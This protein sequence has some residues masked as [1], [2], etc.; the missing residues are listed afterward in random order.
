MKF[1]KLKFVLLVII[2][3]L[4]ITYNV[5]A[6]T[7][8]PFANIKVLDNPKIYPSIKFQDIQGNLVNIKDYSGKIVVLNFWASWCK[9]CKEEM[10]LLDDLQINEKIGKIKIFPI[11]IEKKNIEKAKNF[12]SNNE[13]KNL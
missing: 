4:F 8:P 3:L 11:N 12:F 13:I 9:P 6:T 5:N 1:L 10:P 2:A 7:K